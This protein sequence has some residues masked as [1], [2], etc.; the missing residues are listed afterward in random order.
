MTETFR[1]FGE[2]P[3]IVK[4]PQALE[5]AHKIE[6]RE[7]INPSSFED[8]YGS[9]TVQ[10]D[11]NYVQRRLQQFHAEDF[12]NQDLKVLKERS[13]IFEAI[14]F[15][16]A[17]GAMWF[18]ENSTIIMPSLYDD[19]HNGVDSIVEIERQNGL[20]IAALS[21][22]LTFRK[23]VGKKIK[24]IDEKLQ[25][26]NLTRIKYYQS[27]LGDMRG[28]VS[29]IPH[30]VIGVDGGTLAQLTN[31]FAES[32]SD[33]FATHPVQFQIIESIIIQADFFKGLGEE[34]G[35]ENVVRAYERIGRIFREIY[36]ARKNRVRDLGKRD[37]F[38]E[39]L[40]EVIKYWD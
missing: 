31:L 28:E 1:G 6:E 26:G 33:Q 14:L 37:A 11:Q 24:H 39:N 21:L 34:Y 7:R 18:G 29:N 4:H 23:D 9:E 12:R 15:Q 16:E 17:D 20:S 38:F 30:F 19:I 32:K 36:E 25:N 8:L 22:D 13:D 27:T 35:H 40:T 5:R 3:E 10:R 2:N